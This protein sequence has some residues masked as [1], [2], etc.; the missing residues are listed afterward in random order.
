MPFVQKVTEFKSLGCQAECDIF[1][2]I[3]QACPLWSMPLIRH[4]WAP[5]AWWIK[6][7]T[8]SLS[9]G[10]HP[11]LPKKNYPHLKVSRLSQ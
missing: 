4:L 5:Y 7:E 6:Q 8:T 3:Y 9:Y 1:T 10:K 11:Q 2:E